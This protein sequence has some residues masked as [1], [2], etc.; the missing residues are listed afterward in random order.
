[1]N[2]QM[3]MKRS[4][5]FIILAAVTLLAVGCNNEG[6]TDVPGM[7]LGTGTPLSVTSSGDGTPLTALSFTH[8][9]A[10][11]VLDIEVGSETLR[12]SIESDKTWCKVLPGEHIGSGSFT[13]E[14]EANESFEAREIATLTFVAGESRS[15]LLTVSQSGATFVFPDHYLIFPRLEA[16][17]E[18]DIMTIEGMQWRVDND[19]WIMVEE[20]SSYV[21]DRKKVT[22][23]KIW[24]VDNDQDS[25]YGIITLLTDEQRDTIALY[26]FG[27]DYHYDDEGT[28]VF[29]GDEPASIHFIAPK[30]VVK[31]VVAPDFATVSGTENKDGTVT[32]SIDFDNNRNDGE[33][34]REC[35]VSVV[36]NNSSSTTFT[37]PPTRQDFHPA[38]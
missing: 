23:L 30:Y 16:P 38:G 34:I 8:G 2:V 10:Q 11:K 22:T 17:D 9:P 12:W 24:P 21:Y 15:A 5:S 3:A 36:I 26:Q 13:I 20:I 37:L 27:M 4:L 31:E 35:P 14:V 33:L 1:M 19:E 32:F 25:R 7:S 29:S 6:G 28:I 18:I